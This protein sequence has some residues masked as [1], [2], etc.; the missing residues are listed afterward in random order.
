MK[1]CRTTDF[2]ELKILVVKYFFF[3]RQNHLKILRIQTQNRHV[4]GTEAYLY[5]IEIKKRMQSEPRPL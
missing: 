4:S 5:L 3:F 2:C 1:N